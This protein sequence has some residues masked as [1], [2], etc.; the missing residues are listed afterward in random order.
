MSDVAHS[1]PR[2]PEYYLSYADGLT[3]PTPPNLPLTA[4]EAFGGSL[5][6]P[7]EELTITGPE[8]SKLLKE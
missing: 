5:P 7:L 1:F 2:P 3:W 6:C 8:Y 4:I